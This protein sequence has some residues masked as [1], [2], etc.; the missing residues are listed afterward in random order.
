MSIRPLI[1]HLKGS[2]EFRERDKLALTSKKETN[3]KSVQRKSQLT[4]HDY[5]ASPFLPK[6]EKERERKVDR[7]SG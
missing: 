1:V 7:I 2:V 3:L 6:K 4:S 5:S